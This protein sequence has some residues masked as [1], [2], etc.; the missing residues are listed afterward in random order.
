MAATRG[1]SKDAPKGDALILVSVN[2]LD[3][4]HIYQFFP[5]PDASVPELPTEI[6]KFAQDTIVVLKPWTDSIQLRTILEMTVD[7]QETILMAISDGMCNIMG[8]AYG[9]PWAL[10][11]NRAGFTLFCNDNRF[12]QMSLEELTKRLETFIQLY[13]YI[14]HKSLRLI[15]LRVPKPLLSK[16]GVEVQSFLDHFSNSLNVLLLPANI[17]NKIMEI[18]VIDIHARHNKSELLSCIELLYKKAHHTLLISKLQTALDEL[19]RAMTMEPPELIEYIKGFPISIPSFEAQFASPAEAIGLWNEFGSDLLEK[20][21]QI[22]TMFKELESW[23]QCIIVDTRGGSN[24]AIVIKHADVPNAVAVKLFIE[25]YGESTAIKIQGISSLQLNTFLIDAL[26]S[27]I[28]R[29]LDEVDI[30]SDTIYSLLAMI[31]YSCEQLIQ[32]QRTRRNRVTYTYFNT[33]ETISEMIEQNVRIFDKKILMQ[34]YI[35]LV[36]Y[37]IKQYTLKNIFQNPTPAPAPPRNRN[38]NHNHNRNHTRR[39][40][41]P[42]PA[43]SSALPSAR[44]RSSVR[45]PNPNQNG[46]TRKYYKKHSTHKYKKL[47]KIKR[48]TM[49]HTRNAKVCRSKTRS[50]PRRLR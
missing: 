42:S 6:K 22:T 50:A 48:K 24:K 9:L 14:T 45:N 43:P 34:N 12:R 20:C 16:H 25:L 37:S 41:T 7:L 4:D 19:D 2:V 38:R 31:I 29:R 13:N 3:Q 17:S 11:E 44:S 23:P 15:K 46:G 21:D 49:K 47:N 8:M 26:L 1:K 28:Y 5:H 27:D 30:D 18:K 39:S 32:E 40:R 33:D 35:N 36:E 10:F